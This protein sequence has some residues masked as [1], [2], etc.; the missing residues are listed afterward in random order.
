L[1][2]FIPLPVWGLPQVM[3]G[4][5]D[6]AQVSRMG[7]SLLSI[8]QPCRGPTWQARQAPSIQVGGALL[9]V[10]ESALGSLFLVA[11]SSFTPA[12]GW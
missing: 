10:D 7:I 2:P 8:A 3:G 5:D 12:F 6:L 11:S 9:L 4:R 1:V